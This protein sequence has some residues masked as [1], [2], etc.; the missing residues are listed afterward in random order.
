MR[1]IKSIIAVLFIGLAFSFGSTPALAAGTSIH[2]VVSPKPVKAPGETTFIVVSAQFIP[3]QLQLQLN[4][5]KPIVLTLKKEAAHEY[6]ASF[7][8][9]ST[10]RL[11]VRVTDKTHH[12]LLQDS[13]T[14]SKA[15]SNIAGKVVIAVIFFGVSIWYWRK[16]QRYT[17]SPHTPRK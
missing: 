14:V 11:K 16:A 6:A 12:I 15:P 7:F 8:L 17:Q 13:Y 1:T 9:R 10:G 4:T 2:L 3:D 5:Q